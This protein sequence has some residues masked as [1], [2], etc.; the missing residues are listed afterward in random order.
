MSDA[1]FQ[2]KI[3]WYLP[4]SVANEISLKPPPPGVVVELRTSIQSQAQNK[5]SD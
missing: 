4:A 1:S 2:P 5:K 3:F